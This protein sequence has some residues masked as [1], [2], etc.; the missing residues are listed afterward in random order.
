MP[1]P[2]Q[3]V[4]V[5]GARVDF[6]AGDAQFQ[7]V[8][9]RVIRKQG[10]VQRSFKRTQR[11][12]LA[13]QDA[14]R[15]LVSSFGRLATVA[16]VGILARVGRQSIRS[17]DEIAKIADAT[18]I[19]TTA[20]QEYR[21][22][23]DLAGVATAQ[24]DKAVVFAVKSI[25]ELRTRTTGELT[26][27]LQD[28]DTGLLQV[29]RTSESVEEVIN[30][31]FR[32]MGELED[33]TE[34]AALAKAFFGRS[35]VALVNIVR[36]E[37][38]A[39]DDLR[40]QAH[41]T[42]VVLEEDLL[43]NAERINDELTVLG[44]QIDTRFTRVLFAG[45]ENLHLFAAAGL[46]V[47][48]IYAGRL[49]AGIAFATQAQIAQ[50]VA[51]RAQIVADAQRLAQRVALARVEASA[52]AIFPAQ[53]V[54]QIRRSADAQRTLATA[55]R[56]HAAAQTL[57]ARHT[58][59]AG[60]AQR[61]AAG[62]IG[63]LGGPIGATVTVLTLATAAWI[64]FRR[65]TDATTSSTEMAIA[66]LDR[67]IE[68]RRGSQSSLTEEGRELDRA[69]AQLREL[70]A[71]QNR[72]TE[73][74][75]AAPVG[76]ITGV[77]AT[78]VALR[79][80]Y[81]EIG[82]QIETLRIRIGRLTAEILG[83][84]AQVGD[85]TRGLVADFGKLDLSL[86]APLE[87]SRAFAVAIE[88]ANAATIRRARF[89][90][91]IAGRSERDRARAAASFDAQIKLDSERL[92]LADELQTAERR[93]ARSLEVRDLARER[94]RGLDAVSKAG[95]EA[96][97][98]VKTAEN[99]VAAQVKL[100]AGLKSQLEFAQALRINE[101]QIGA[102]VAATLAR[103]RAVTLAERP[104]V[105][106]PEFERAQRDAGIFTRNLE[107]QVVA[108]QRAAEQ[109][110][111]IARAPAG[112]ARVQLQ[113]ELEI[114][115]RA[116]EERARATAELTRALEDHAAA[117]RDLD[118][119]DEA[120]LR[121][122]RERHTSGGRARR[123]GTPG[124]RRYGRSSAA[125]DGL[126]VSTRQPGGFDWAR[127]PRAR[128]RPRGTDALYARYRFFQ[129]GDGARHK[130]GSTLRGFDREFAARG[131]GEFYRAG[132]FDHRRSDPDP[133]ARHDYTECLTGARRESERRAGIGGLLSRVGG[134]FTNLFGG[135]AAGPSLA[136]T[137]FNLGPG[138]PVFHGGG[139][140][141]RRGLRRNEV[142]GIVV[143]AGEEI[144]KRSDPR[145]R[146]NLR[147]GRDGG[148]LEAIRIEIVNRSPVPLAGAVTSQRLDARTLVA[149]VML[150]DARRNGEITQALRLGVS[151][152]IT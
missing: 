89:E 145:H 55:T 5:G 137:S 44:K 51:T 127:G 121:G 105:T 77:S 60:V 119:A 146:D 148:G 27:A 4:R 7:R 54:A 23:A 116:T 75:A 81:A 59:A 48:G 143:E 14:N 134:F 72:L 112:D 104:D 21:F 80:R 24:L 12:A 38:G 131:R 88:R 152:P 62:A 17:A 32:R 74:I 67:L 2:N 140:V 25:G 120:R 97:G 106:R 73:Q 111:R 34:R 8:S 47:A 118:R 50:T 98:Q 142:P 96:R 90:T 117:A 52:A 150:D 19:S 82:R 15:R 64:A 151:Q 13:A 92:R 35:G 95:V 149:T 71:E 123:R 101:E 115:T 128:R 125:G 76:A 45:I 78:A 79:S 65:E 10:D 129:S 133:C 30:A 46:T 135:G 110:E 144:L 94:A 91:S 57:L 63:F 147:A 11:G 16:G 42:G 40:R 109:A 130:W 1:G 114:I 43:R 85:S 141:P 49:A 108:Q 124:V 86:D 37:A 99:Q 29:A 83:D 126:R 132:E 68:R 136:P 6:S 3:S 56:E 33:A 26:T 9:N 113:G 18:G 122:G 138:A 84:D 31:V 28:F 41:E 22:A 69:R 102:V 53:S 100:V 103:R 87:K 61:G 36:G 39:F 70:A 93:H 107:A 58:T 139:I 66:T 20:L